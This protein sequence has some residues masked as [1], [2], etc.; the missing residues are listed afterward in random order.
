M[1]IDP[2]L[3]I[4]DPELASI[5]KG[6][7][8]GSAAGAAAAKKP[9]PDRLGFGAKVTDGDGAA[10]GG[11]AA[12]PKQ[13]VKLWVQSGFEES[14]GRWVRERGGRIVSGG[15]RVLVAE[16]PL[17]E[18]AS[19]S[20][21]EGLVRAGAPKRL[22]PS[23]E[24]CRGEAT[25]LTQALSRFPL[26]GKGVVVGIIDTGV[27]WSHPDFVAPD[28]RS[29]IEVFLHAHRDESRGE[30]RFDIY[31]R[32]KLSAALKGPRRTVP[33][34]DPEGHGTHCASIAAG[35]GRASQGRFSGVAP[36]ATLMTVRAEPLDDDLVISALRELFRRAGKRPA[37]IS[38]SLGHHQ[39]AHDG[40]AALEN[41][42]AEHS[43]PGRIVVVAAGNEGSA[44][45]HWHGEMTEGEELAVPFRIADGWQFVDLW[46]PRGDEVE[47]WVET[48]A[49]VRVPKS[50]LFENSGFGR[51]KATWR[52]DPV[53]L[54]GNF[55]VIVE[56]GTPDDVWTLRIRPVTVLH[57]QLHAWSGTYNPAS[58][59]LFPGF[60]GRGYSIGIPA[61]EE[62]AI[63]VG[64]W[65]CRDSYEGPEG[66]V[67]AE[68][69]VGGLS[70]FSSEGPT[71]HGVQK[72]DIAAPGHFITAAL[73]AGSAA[74]AMKSRQVPELPYI[75][76]QG[77]SMA[78]PFVAGVIALMLERE[79]RLTPEEIQQRLRAT[80]RRDRETGRVWGAGFGYGKIDVEA[81]LSY[82]A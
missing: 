73:S 18:I 21:V 40:T 27:D 38:L 72:P 14:V 26:T 79:P 64:S 7:A 9:R 16:L 65:I 23:L 34:G 32:T 33:Q 74:A 76:L 48:P 53:N 1:T 55:N 30:S 67:K 43:G 3:S 51:C 69:Q 28:G 66:L 75:T 61:T 10:G 2:E 22:L 68:L 15:E 54:D 20:E 57:G 63:S 24:H 47:V 52:R 4:F 5:A 70:P 6:Y 45:I 78:T 71:R 62:R 19:L 81:L 44:G 80:A 13:S 41:V 37:V 77:T 8:A 60:S 29:R 49:G 25:G 58:G 11:G 17:D 56:H 42:I 36:E 59:A 31:N 39:G 50:G 12:V 35:N 82:P 46:V